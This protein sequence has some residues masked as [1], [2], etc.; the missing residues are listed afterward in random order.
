[1]AQVYYTTNDFE[2]IPKDLL[3]E[4]DNMGMDDSLILTVP[5]G[6]YFNVLYN[7][8]KKD[9]DLSGKKVGFLTGGYGTTKSDKKTYFTIERDR[10]TSN[11]PP[12]PG[13]LYIFDAAQKEKSGGY[14]AAIV[15]WSKRIVPIKEVVKVLKKKG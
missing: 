15:Y 6:N 9:F 1:M 2:S 5:E 3:N 12:S 4:L 10:W 7:L 11:Y 14:D 8:G 13:V